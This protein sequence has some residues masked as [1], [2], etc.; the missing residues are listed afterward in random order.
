MPV[1]LKKTFQGKIS[2]DGECF[3]WQVSSDEYRRIMGVKAYKEELSY[4]K[5]C[6]KEMNEDYDES[7][8]NWFIYPGDIVG[9][10]YL[11]NEYKFTVTIE[12]V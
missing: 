9:Y 4:R 7:E 6:A 2:G 5:E 3:C 8:L 12:D 1:I 11:Y 10:N